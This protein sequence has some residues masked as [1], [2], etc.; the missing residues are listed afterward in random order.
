[1]NRS[2]TDRTETGGHRDPNMGKFESLGELLRSQ[3]WGMRHEKNRIELGRGDL[4]LWV[5]RLLLLRI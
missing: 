2:L 5:N 1:M 3:I 4:K